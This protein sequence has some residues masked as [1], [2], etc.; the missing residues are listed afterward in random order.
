MEN[1]NQFQIQKI[2]DELRV[3]INSSKNI[4]NRTVAND[5][6]YSK[7]TI[8]LFLNN[9]YSRGDEQTLAAKIHKYLQERKQFQD[10]NYEIEIVKTRAM[11]EI[12]KVANFV[13]KRKKM[14][15]IFG[16]PGTGKS[17][18]IKSFEEKHSSIVRI[19]AVPKIT[20]KSLFQIIHNHKHLKLSGQGTV[21]SM[22][23]ETCERLEG[24]NITFI[25]DEAENLPK[26]CLELIRRTWDFAKIGVLL[27]GTKQLE[28]N[29]RGRRGEFAQLYS[30]IGIKHEIEALTE[31]DAEKIV[32]ANLPGSNGLWRTFYSYSKKNARILGNLIDTCKDISE[33]YNEEITT[34]MIAEAATTLI[35]Q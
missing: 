8:S 4:S 2:R 5:I 32:Q 19:E 9:N 29:L 13:K 12:F 11:A 7:T 10:G 1:M 21:Y 30:R 24:S 34:D 35:L 31:N 28:A 15:L 16:A 25:F 20:A 17:E 33:E 23:L 27:V 22:F 6:G 18:A 3:Y 14:G 26:E